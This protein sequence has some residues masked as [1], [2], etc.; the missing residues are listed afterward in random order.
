MVG[1]EGSLRLSAVREYLSTQGPSPSTGLWVKEMT[2]LPVLGADE[3]FEEL[4]VN[5]R[6]VS[7]QVAGLGI[8]S[9]AAGA[10]RPGTLEYLPFLN[11]YLPRFG[12]HGWP[13]PSTENPY[14]RA[15]RL[16]RHRTV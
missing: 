1:S 10:E 9:E 4:A 2:F 16:C 7:G 6:A 8:A 15:E 12:G 13:H 14:E 5:F 11:T 3:L